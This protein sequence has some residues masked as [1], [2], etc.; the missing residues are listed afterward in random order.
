MTTSPGDMIWY[1]AP[2]GDAHAQVFTN[3]RAIEQEQGEIFD[4]LALLESLYDPH[5]PL[6]EA[7]G[8]ISDVVDNVV[9]ANVDTTYASVA[10]A[11]VRPRFLTD[12]ASWKMQRRAKRLEYYAE[13]LGEQLS[14]FKKCRLA[15]KEAEKKGGGLV[16]VHRT[17]WDEPAV[18]HVRLEDI[19]VPDEDSR[20]G[21][22]PMQ[23]HHVQRSYDRDQLKAEYPDAAD[24]IDNIYGSR[25]STSLNSYSS[26][27]LFAR[28]KITVI[29]SIR[30]PIGKR[31]KN[32]AKPASKKKGDKDT[33]PSA[34]R[35]VPGRRTVTIEHKTLHDEPYH[36]PH[37]PYAMM[38]WSE[39]QGSFYPI[40]GSE[41][42][43]GHQNALNRRT[44]QINRILD[45]NAMVTVFVRPADAGLSVKTTKIGNTVAIKG[46]MPQAPILPAVH[47]EVMQS[48]KDLRQNS[49]DAFGQSASLARGEI[50]AGLETGAAVR[51][52]RTTSTQH[53][54]PQEMDFEEFVL[55][56]YVLLVDVCKD[57]GDAAPRVLKSRW[58]KPID[59]AD[60][61]MGDV[62]IQIEAASTLPRSPA[63]REQ[64]I[65]EWA[66][67]GVISTE[68]FRR[69]INS[70]DLDSEL[71]MYSSALEVIDMQ[72]EQILD[73]GISTPEPQ[74]NLAMAQWRGTGAFNNARTADAPEDVL[75]E[76]RNYINY[77]AH[78]LSQTQAQNENAA[79]GAGPDAAM[80]GPAPGDAAL[81]GGAPESALSP[82]AMQLRATAAA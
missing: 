35:Y 27:S 47:P 59:W 28:R 69:M 74:D 52:F 14:M 6:G 53:W 42:I 12:G 8:S 30:L 63:G 50:P 72:L 29:E 40:S 48:Q 2:Q 45:Q 23:L 58:K 31:P 10:T 82:Q 9:A 76:L 67:A 43:A 73:G 64:T 26:G 32:D 46:D 36:K 51:E 71:S 13:G 39:R 38:T 7:K 1:D 80:A 24:D 20:T 33:K 75:E 55:V 5:S 66:Q 56:A 15:F 57:L 70:P 79:M 19:Y 62:K 44:W 11:E 25:S 18:D 22:P 16:K 41:R 37:Y 61:D 65:F 21:A 78:I 4:R 77:A 81:P 17:R 3:V 60:V 34:A 54:S 68:S 49:F